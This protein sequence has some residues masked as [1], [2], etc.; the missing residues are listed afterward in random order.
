MP[1]LHHL[2]APTTQAVHT[3]FAKATRASAWPTVFLRAPTPAQAAPIVLPARPIPAKLAMTEI[4]ARQGKPCN[5]TAPA[6]AAQTLLPTATGAHGAAG[7][8]V[9]VEIK[10][11]PGLAWVQQLAAAPTTARVP[12]RKPVPA[13]SQTRLFA[14]APGANCRAGELR[15]ARQ[16]EFTCPKPLQWVT[17]I[18]LLTANSMTALWLQSGQLVLRARFFIKLVY[19]AA[20][21]PALLAAHGRT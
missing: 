16:W 5:A 11:E 3:L 14:T 20:V 2:T 10:P 9:R 1:G 6:G 8:R 17:R 21:Q 19:L 7:V 4:P 12:P 18:R 13:L 15:P